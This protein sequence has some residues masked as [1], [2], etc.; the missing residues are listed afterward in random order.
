MN[1]QE[2]VARRRFIEHLD[3]QD[4]TAR[5]F[6]FLDWISADDQGRKLLQHL[7][8]VDVSGLMEETDFQHPPQPGTPEEVAAVALCIADNAK[9]QKTELFQ[10]AS[11]VGVEGRSSD[12]QEVQDEL[13][14][15]YLHPFY[16]YLQDHLFP[17]E[18][19]ANTPEVD[20]VP[21]NTTDVFIVHG[22]D[23]GLKETVARF[24]SRLGLNPVILHEQADRGRTVIEKF[25]DHAEVGFALVLLTPDDVGGFA[26]GETRPRARQNVVFELG[27]FLG[28]LGRS[29]VVAL[30][31]GEDLELPSDYAGVIYTA[32]DPA[33][34]WKFLLVRELRAAG[35]SV[36]ANQAL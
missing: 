29:R 10:I 11:A 12:I 24:V 31:Q 16:D 18:K 21:L 15:R 2:F 32:V 27:Y 13:E 28:L 23:N 6:S 1:L 7:R 8:E 30:R 34:A 5:V 36:D 33:G 26:G 20:P 22:R 25:E 4:A 19:V 3:F 35:F 17:N 9:E 14:K